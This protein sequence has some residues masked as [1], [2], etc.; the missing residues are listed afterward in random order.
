M[1]TQ[2]T[3][4]DASF[5]YLETAETPQSVASVLL[6]EL[7]QG[8]SGSF[9]E[10]YKKHVADRIHLT[11]VLKLKLMPLPFDLDHPFWVE[12]ENLD[13]DYH[14]R[15]HTL[16]KPGRIADLEM[17][18]GRLHSNFLDR[19]RPLWEF[20]VIDGLEDG[21]VALYTKLHHTCMDGASSKALIA[22][23]YDQ[24]PAGRVIPP[25][26]SPAPRS[27]KA[28]VNEVLKG[29]AAHFVR[30][31]I[32]AI[33]FVPEVLKAWAKLALPDPQ[34]LEF[35]SAPKPP[36]PT[37][38]TIFNV[39]ITSQRAYAMRT[40]PFKTMKRIAKQAQCKL[41][42]IVLAVC[43]GALRRYLIEKDA[44]PAET[45]TALV[46]VALAQPE[47]NL[48]ANHNTIYVCSLATDIAD[49]YARLIAIR[50]SSS[51]QKELLGN[52]KNALL[53]DLSVIGSGTLM[54]GM[55]D[56]Y[57]RAKIADRMP[58][59]GNLVISNVAISPVPLY[60]A[61]GKITTFNPCSIPF[62][63]TALNITVQSYCDSMDFGLIACRRTVPDVSKL[64]DYMETGLAELEVAVA[65][66]VTELAAT[67]R[68]ALG[69]AAKL[70]PPARRRAS[71]T[72]VPVADTPSDTPP[73]AASKA[74]AAKQRKSKTKRGAAQAKRASAKPSRKK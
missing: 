59:I 64:A 72:K 53:P 55:V 47:G 69:A 31:E 34:T 19:S 51:A 36:P 40:L 70:P 29:I 9:Y 7:P 50:D 73:P 4:Q 22:A 3:E 63:G 60:I 33:Q 12:E 17:L 18:I 61:G 39:G 26:P 6:V 42:D 14:I 52:I 1:L 21:R 54:R 41:N 56:L 10:D 16:P 28:L 20:Y 58:P 43:S 15:R 8:Y 11:P 45:L 48:E 27:G 32:R 24:A 74:R 25:P 2:L 23:M 38:K 5:L 30:Q 37:P 67:P 65:N 66:R 13:I 71:R 44:L 57:S 35:N 49:P 62:H 46:P 68:P